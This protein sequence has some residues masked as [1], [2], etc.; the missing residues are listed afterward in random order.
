MYWEALNDCSFVC[1]TVYMR[2]CSDIWKI[3]QIC[4]AITPFHAPLTQLS[5]QFAQ[6]FCNG[7]A[8]ENYDLAMQL[9]KDTLLARQLA[10]R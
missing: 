5:D 9:Q 1:S 3:A 10:L 6:V 7:T 2:L 4:Q 8:V